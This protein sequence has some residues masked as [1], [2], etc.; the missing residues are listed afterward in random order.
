MET[1]KA[2]LKFIG[3]ELVLFVIGA[4]LYMGIE[5]LYRGYTH[6]TMGV[7]GGLCFVI[8][9]LLNEGCGWRIPF[10]RQC[11]IGACVV[12]FFEFVSGFI[13]NIILGLNI[14]DYSNMP[15]NILGQVCLPFSII[16]FFLSGIAIIVDD[17]LRYW[18]FG[19]KKPE[20]FKF[21]KLKNF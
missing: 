16:W 18:L 10:W 12:T 2:I 11:L 13:L 20:Y 4:F 7:V 3:E 21:D 5:I 9:G 1:F 14:W 19:G 17:Y 8:I 15:F 6:W